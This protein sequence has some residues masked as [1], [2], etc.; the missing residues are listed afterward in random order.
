MLG[1]PATAPRRL[2]EV[3]DLPLSVSCLLPKVPDLLVAL[4]RI[5]PA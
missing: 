5:L 2:S 3:L 1:L 4:P